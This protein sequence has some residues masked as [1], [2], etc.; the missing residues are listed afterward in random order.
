MF[1]H[2]SAQFPQSPVTSI[3]TKPWCNSCQEKVAFLHGG[4]LRILDFLT[5]FLWYYACFQKLMGQFVSSSTKSLC[6]SRRVVLEYSR[7]QIS[8][9]VWYINVY[10]SSVKQSIC[11]HLQRL[12]THLWWTMDLEKGKMSFLL[13]PLETAG[14]NLVDLKPHLWPQ[15]FAIITLQ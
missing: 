8:I 4:L 7:C 5:F 10:I 11:M 15:I 9:W 13:L 6:Q 14:G 12:L 2:D 3:N 1:W